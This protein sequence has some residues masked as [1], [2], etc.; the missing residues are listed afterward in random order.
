[1]KKLV[2]LAEQRRD[3]SNRVPDGVAKPPQAGKAFADAVPVGAKCDR[4]RGTQTVEPARG[5]RDLAGI[6]EGQGY[7]SPGC[8][9]RG[10]RNRR[11]GERTGV[12]G[13][14]LHSVL[15]KTEQRSTQPHMRKVQG[16]AE[17]QRQGRKRGRP[18]VAHCCKHLHLKRRRTRL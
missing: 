11:L 16:R 18:V 3:R 4:G 1:M 2:A 7:F 9:R 15:G 17:L 8:E 13:I 6:L 5:R 10:Q 12:V 14:A